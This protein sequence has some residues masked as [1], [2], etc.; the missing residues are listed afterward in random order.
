MTVPQKTSVQDSVLVQ[1]RGFDPWQIP[2][3]VTADF[4]DNV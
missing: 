4:A 2:A 1:A 3:K